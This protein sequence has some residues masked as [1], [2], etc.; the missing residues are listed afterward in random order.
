MTD[1]PS[2]RSEQNRRVLVVDD[3]PAVHASFQAVLAAGDTPAEAFGVNFQVVAATGG[4]AGCALARAAAAEGRPFALAFVCMCANDGLVGLATVERLWSDCHDL[5]VVVC[6]AVGA[7]AWER[8]VQ[9][10]GWTDRLLVLQTPID[11]VEVRHMA[12]ALT[13]T[14]NLQQHSLSVLETMNERVRVRTK[15]LERARDELLEINRALQVARVAAES[16]NRTKTMFL[17]NVSHELRTPITA[18]LGYAEELQL[19]LANGSALGD[20][21]AALETI[22][23]NAKHLVGLIG[24]LLDIAKLEA[25]KLVVERI[26]CDAVRMVD[27]VLDSMRP[28]ADRKGVALELEFE[29]PVPVTIVSDPLRLRQIVV[30]L[31][32]NAIKFSRNGTIRVRLGLRAERR[33]LVVAV[34][35]EGCGMAPEVLQRVFLP[36]EQADVSTTRRHGGTGLGLAISRQLAELLGGSLTATSQQGVGSCFTVEVD[37][38]SLDGVT[39]TRTRPTPAGSPQPPASAPP[40]VAGLRVLLA[41]DGP[42][43]QRLIASILHRAGV[44][45]TIAGNG[46]ECLVLALAPDAA[47]DLVIMDIQMPVMDGLTAAVKLRD[48]GCRLPIV[49]LTASAMPSDRRACM[50]AGCDEFLPKPIDRKALIEVIERLAR[51]PS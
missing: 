7:A 23:R 10:L 17:A 46:E 37:A 50:Q 22:T 1:L 25:G 43:N 16:A 27:E 18:I 6:T 45:T 26:P 47:F 33:R 36:F 8:E 49:A 3:D 44:R 4:E 29:T 21:G 15:E 41:E 34:Q 12:S 13:H 38:G 48:A 51:Q 14:W 20:V 31:V 5:Q 9:R 2:H 35:D 19:D 30:N 32:E 24:D 40:P 42:D 39:L 11:P 28:R